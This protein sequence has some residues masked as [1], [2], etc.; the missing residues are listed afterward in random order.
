M[1]L[2]EVQDAGGDDPCEEFPSKGAREA[3][4]VAVVHPDHLV[5]DNLSTPGLAGTDAVE[6]Y[7]N[8]YQTK[9]ERFSMVWTKRNIPEWFNANI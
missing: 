2:C 7:R 8:F 3:R 9:Q 5:A 4:N 6:S 1:E